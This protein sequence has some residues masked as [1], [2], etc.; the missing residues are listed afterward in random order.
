M[1]KRNRDVDQNKDENINITKDHQSVKLVF[2]K[3]IGI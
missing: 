2:K 1:S 3:N